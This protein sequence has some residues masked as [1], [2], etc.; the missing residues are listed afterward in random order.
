RL[1]NPVIKLVC[2]NSTLSR[3]LPFLSDL[4]TT[5]FIVTLVQLFFDRL[6]LPE[7]LAGEG[8]SPD[9]KIRVIPHNSSEGEL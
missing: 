5:Q 1:L 7:S 3:G 8:I 2:G 9:L 6:N 4:K